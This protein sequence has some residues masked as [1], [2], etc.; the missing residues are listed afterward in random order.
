MY[1][2]NWA[3]QVRAP[4]P[5]PFVYLHT[6]H[7]IVIRYY[8]L[9]LRLVNNLCTKHVVHEQYSICN[10]WYSHSSVFLIEHPHF[11]FNWPATSLAYRE[12]KVCVNKLYY[13][14]EEQT[15][16]KQDK[17]KDKICNCYCSLL[18]CPCSLVSVCGWV[19]GWVGGCSLVI[20]TCIL[21]TSIL[22]LPCCSC[23]SVQQITIL[24]Y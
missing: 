24:Y 11:K 10:G 5:P 14:Q 16:A 6:A 7:D 12:D 17:S 23:T 21:T 1:W 8:S 9:T 20:I 3:W 19:D 2:M 15:G 22:N 4:A 13:T 18:S